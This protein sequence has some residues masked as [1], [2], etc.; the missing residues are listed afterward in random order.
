VVPVDP[1][2]S[3]SS[4]SDGVTAPQR[5][6]VVLEVPEAEADPLD[7]FDQVVER[8][9]GSVGHLGDVEV[10]QLSNDFVIVIPSRWTSGGIAFLTQWCFITSLLLFLGRLPL[11][12]D[13]R[14]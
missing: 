5:T 6:T 9:G 1:R 12:V 3:G 14:L 10:A 2:R 7:A 13:Q 4:D 11:L 8:F